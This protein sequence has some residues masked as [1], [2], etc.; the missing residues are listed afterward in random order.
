[1]SGARRVL[2]VLMLLAPFAAIAVFASV[3]LGAWWAGPTILVGCALII[4]WLILAITW[5][6]P[7]DQR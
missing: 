2:A 4:V 6:L 7:G 5:L 1:M 3:A